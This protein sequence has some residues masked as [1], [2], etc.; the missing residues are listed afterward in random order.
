M[1]GDERRKKG[2]EEEMGK[3][4]EKEAVVK[5][6]ERSLATQRASSLWASLVVSL[7]P[8]IPTEPIRMQ[9]CCSKPNSI[10]QGGMPPHGRAWSRKS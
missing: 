5:T 6:Q 7:K 9:C 10:T 2:R 3:E 4:K 8:K 1:E